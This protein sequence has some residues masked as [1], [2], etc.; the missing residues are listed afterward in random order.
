M[1]NGQYISTPPW[2]RPGTTGLQNYSGGQIVGRTLPHQNYDPTDYTYKLLEDPITYFDSDWGVPTLSANA[3]STV[4][5]YRQ[6]GFDVSIYG[7]LTF[8]IIANATS[9]GFG[10][11][12]FRLPIKPNS[13]ASQTSNIDPLPIGLC[14]AY[15]L[16]ATTSYPGQVLINN[17][18]PTTTAITPKGL[19]DPSCY[20]T[21]YVTSGSNG[22]ASV[23][24][25]DGGTL[26]F[27]PFT[28]AVGD[29]IYFNINY[30]AEALRGVV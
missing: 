25:N 22:T 19:K 30:E 11:L 17:L 10:K 6:V 18:A 5:R 29:S 7:R 13:I 21:F 26:A 27:D 8:N 24:N 14:N 1:E 16:S 28:W 9:T 12:R 15:D 23:Y 4:V 2:Q 3:I 20:F